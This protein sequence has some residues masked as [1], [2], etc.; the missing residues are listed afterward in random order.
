MLLSFSDYAFGIY[1]SLLAIGCKAYMMGDYNATMYFELLDMVGGASGRLLQVVMGIHDHQ[2]LGPHYIAVQTEQPWFSAGTSIYPM[3]LQQAV[4]V[5]MYC[6]RHRRDLSVQYG[7]NPDRIQVVPL[8]SVSR[9]DRYIGTA[10]EYQHDVLFFGSC[11]QRRI[12][13]LNE[14]VI[15]A[16]HYGIT[17]AYVCATIKSVLFAEALDEKILSSRLVI[18]LHAEEGSSLEVHRI[19]YV[20]SMGVPVVSE[21]SRFDPETDAEYEN[22]SGVFFGGSVDELFTQALE[23]VRNPELR[24]RASGQA[25]RKYREVNQ[26]LDPLRAA[27]ADAEAKMGLSR[28][29]QKTN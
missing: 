12:D 26:Q 10:V 14:L 16:D 20:L 17:V 24:S 18:N 23:L 7:V 2:I 1:Q 4:T 8:Y 21:R 22:S 3:K 11:T 13:I 19:I 27:M 29:G 28:T 5:W 25:L 15:L 9:F 6:E